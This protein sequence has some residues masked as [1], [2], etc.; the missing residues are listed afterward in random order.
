M[1]PGKIHPEWTV[2]LQQTPELFGRDHAV[3]RSVALSLLGHAGSPVPERG[4]TSFRLVLATLRE[5]HPHPGEAGHEE[6][7]I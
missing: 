6:M 5:R 1:S 3:V 4:V 7:G 2:G